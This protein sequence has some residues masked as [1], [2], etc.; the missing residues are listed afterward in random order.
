LD[1]GSGCGSWY[2]AQ[3]EE[4]NERREDKKEAEG[5]VE[6]RAND[7]ERCEEEGEQEAVKE[8][9]GED[10]QAEELEAGRDQVGIARG[11]HLCRWERAS[12]A[13]DED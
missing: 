8:E 10:E 4:V 1:A 13:L 5:I 3:D 6:E 2:R 11:G 9:V 12:V 7:S